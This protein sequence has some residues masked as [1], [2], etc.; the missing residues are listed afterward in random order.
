MNNEDVMIRLDNVSKRYAMGTGSSKPKTRARSE[1]VIVHALEGIS[2]EIGQGEFVSIMGPSGSGKSTLLHILGALDQPTEGKYLLEGLDISRL[3]D[4]ELAKVRNKHFGFVFQSYNLFPE[5]TALENVMIP[6]RY[7]QISVN[8][9]RDRA[10]ERLEQVGLGHRLDHYP[11]QLSGGEQQRVAIARA[12]IMK[13]TLLL[14]DE[15]T[16]N[17]SQEMGDE[18]L[19]LFQA[20]HLEGTSLVIVTHDPRVGALAERTLR[21]KDGQIERDEAVVKRTHLAVA[22]T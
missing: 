11:S 12:L 10:L 22:S 3:N 18:I 7:S 5:K 19:M 20:L 2:L 9:R 6:M 15:P 17:L 8:Q 4:G 1:E 21:I 14:A 13:P 16:G